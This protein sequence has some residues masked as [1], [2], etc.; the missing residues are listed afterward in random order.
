MLD[1]G[2]AGTGATGLKEQGEDPGTELENPCCSEERSDGGLGE[3]A[4]EDSSGLLAEGGCRRHPNPVQPLRPVP[5]L[6]FRS[7]TGSKDHVLKRS[8]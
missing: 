5:G 6:P 1:G 7:H 3:Q 4:Q 2:C 8:P